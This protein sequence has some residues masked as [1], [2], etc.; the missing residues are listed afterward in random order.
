MLCYRKSHRTRQLVTITFHIIIEGE[1]WVQ[2]GID[3]LHL[4]LTSSICRL[5]N[6]MGTYLLCCSFISWV[7]LDILRKFMLLICYYAISE[8]DSLTKITM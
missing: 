5:L 7:C 1:L 8:A 3:V 4:D 6:R 2:L